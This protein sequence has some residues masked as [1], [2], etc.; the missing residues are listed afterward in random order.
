MP[1]F[2]FIN[3]L[4]L[5]CTRNLPKDANSS[6][7]VLKMEPPMPRKQIDPKTNQKPKKNRTYRL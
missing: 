3:K 7:R 4:I 2:V 5:K 6:R 1:K